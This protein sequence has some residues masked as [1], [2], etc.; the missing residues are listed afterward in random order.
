MPW[1][2]PICC[3]RINR[4]GLRLCLT[5]AFEMLHQLQHDLLS[6]PRHIL[7]SHDY[8]DSKGRKRYKYSITLPSPAL[9]AGDNKIELID[10]QRGCCL[11]LKTTLTKP[12]PFPKHLVRMDET[13]VIYPT[14]WFDSGESCARFVKGWC[15]DHGLTQQ[16]VEMDYT[17]PTPKR[18]GRFPLMGEAVTWTGQPLDHVYHYPEDSIDPVRLLV[19]GDLEPWFVKQRRWTKVNRLSPTRWSVTAPCCHQQ[20]KVVAEGWLLIECQCRQERVKAKYVLTN[21]PHILFRDTL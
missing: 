17:Y 11:Y 18:M 8:T 20:A 12:L 10:Y 21:R 7:V 1:T 15:L 6:R 14:V 16:E 5:Y 2:K 4:I 9:S 19:Q 13:H 3:R